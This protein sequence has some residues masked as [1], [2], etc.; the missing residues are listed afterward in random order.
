MSAKS[1]RAKQ[2]APVAVAVPPASGPRPWMYA[3]GI[4]AALFAV[5]EVYWPA[6]HGPFLL[7][8]SYLPYMAASVNPALSAWVKGL[9]PLLMFS[10]WLNYQSAGNQDT[11]PYHLF[12]IV[13]HFLNGGL[14]LL[15][16]RKVL[17]WARVEAWKNGVLSIFAAGLFL[18]HPLQTE[19]VSY[20]ASRSETLS[21]FFVLAAFVVFLYRVGESVS[22]ARAIAVLALF[23]AAVASKEH[24]AVLP[25][26]LLLTDYYWNPGFS[27]DGI[28]RNWRLYI[29]IVIGSLA[30]FAFVLSV[31][32]GATTAGF[33]VKDF[34][35]YQ[36]FF[37]QCRVVWEYIAMFVLPLGQNVDPDIPVSH[38]L[39]EHFAILG[40]LGLLGATAAAWI[41]RRRFPVASY[42]W[43]TFLILIAPTSSFVPINDVFAER[44][45][46]LPYIGLL[47]VAVDFL[48]R[49]KTT[50]TTM[51]AALSVVLVAEAAATYQRNQLWGSSIDLW[52]DSVAKSPE[53]YRPRF[54]LAFAYFLAGDNGDA[55]EQFQKVAELGKPTYELLIDWALAYDASGKL[56]QALDK[57]K[58][59]AAI[60]QTAHV[61][62]QIGMVYGK[63]GKYPE[64]LDALATAQHLNSKFAMTYYTRGNVYEQQGNR[65]QAAEEYRHALSLNSQ[66][67]VARDALARVSQ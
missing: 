5:L 2:P 6:I 64:A 37:T 46:Y 44:R 10:F 62:S 31:L 35:W 22:F 27:L 38:T 17:S 47:F 25:A 20:I 21:V 58:Q 40:L 3:A 13:L 55:I 67:Q 1:K 50:R 9:R 49:W 65:V 23:G 57:L 43:F 12:N 36:Y 16:V 54:Q 63:M 18:L 45:L 30:A 41:Y 51:I 15:A 7:D 42:G 8:D 39:L 59:A 4:V 52:K 24:T 33:G 60:E 66:L 61:Y 53:K 26:V 48:G 32:K 29:P 11:F 14:I 28:R 34:T 19:S 56:D